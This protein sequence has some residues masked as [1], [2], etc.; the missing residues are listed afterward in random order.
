MADLE[1]DFETRSLVDLPS[2][3]PHVYFEHPSARVLLGSFKLGELRFRWRYG[4]PCPAPLA[5]H[6]AAGGT[7][8]AHNAG[9]EALCFKWLHAHLGWPLPDLSQ[10]R[11]TAA[12]ARAMQ[13]PAS[14]GKLGDAL[15]L[16]VQKDKEGAR[17]MR[18][19]SIPKNG[20]FVAEPEDRPDEFEAYHRYCDIDVETEAEADSRMVPLSETEQAVW[21]LTERINH[22]GVRIDVESARAGLRLAEK[23]KRTL[24][25]E[26]AALTGGVVRK[27][28]E[29][30]KL[31]AWIEEQG[32]ALDSLGKADLEEVLHHDDLPS[33]VRQAIELRMEA[34][35]TSTAKLA[36]MLKRACRDGRVRGEAVYHAAG[37]GRTQSAGVNLNNLPRPRKLYEDAGIR[38]DVLFDAIR[39]GDPD[40]L[41]FLYGDDLGRPLHLL[42]DAIRGFIW[43]APNH[44]LIQADYSNIEGVIVAW[45]AREEWKL[46]ANRKIFSD[47]TVPDLY[48]QTAAKILGIPL[49]EVTKKHWAR[50]AVGKP[51][52]LGLSYQGSVNAF[53]TFARNGGVKLDTIAAPVLATATEE[54]LEKAAKRYENNFKRNQARARELP[55]DVWMA[56][57]IIKNGWRAQNAAIA[58][59][60]GDLEAAA[61]EAVATP[62][63][64]AT[65]ARVSYKVAWGYLWALLPSGR[66]LCYGAPQL[67]AQVWAKVLLDDGTWSDAEVMERD[68]AEK[69]ELAGKIRIQGDTSAKVTAMSVNSKTKAW[70]RQAL[71]GG[72]LMEN[73]L[74]ADTLV[75]TPYGVKRI[76]D[77]TASDLVWDGDAWVAHEGLVRQGSRMT[78]DVAGVRLTPEHKILTTQGWRRAE[79]TDIYEALAASSEPE[80]VGADFWP[81]DGNRVCR[82]R[83]E[84]NLVAHA[85]RVRGG[86]NPRGRG[87]SQGAHAELRLPAK[88]SAASRENPRDVA[89]PGLSCMA[90]HDR[91]MRKPEAQSVSAL[92]WARD[93]C[94]RGMALLPRLLGRHGADLR[95]WADAG[96]GKQCRGVPPGELCL[97]GPEG[98][99][100]QYSGEPVSGNAARRHVGM[101]SVRGIGYWSDDASVPV[102]GGLA[103]SA[104]VRS[105]GPGSEDHV[106]PVFDLLNAGPRHRFTVLSSAGPIIVSNCT[107]GTARDVLVN[108]MFKAE[109]AGYPIILTVYDEIIAEVPRG[110]GDLAA[111]EKLICELPPWAEG[112]PIAAGGFRAKRYKK[113]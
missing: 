74:G 69:G 25:K 17:L 44:D 79:N 13:L 47:K 7:L 27:C 93:I 61:R 54:Q 112:L 52:E 14:L 100:P 113:D 29:V 85:L 68:V 105:A 31:T 92:R 103:Y 15:G 26:M 63:A 39:E 89:A 86:T 43:A 111:F 30:A 22:R 35:K 83:R 6:I 96:A 65:A 8:K 20:A 77:V 101:R 90:Q 36:T 55:R 5:A 64:T 3:G 104:P 51:A 110:F 76:V 18:I 32:V 84:E 59:S 71:Y 75:F 46:E 34:A 28:S 2:C 9:F 50:Q 24:D 70:T 87:T 11:C 48:R 4:E 106:E 72:L 98:A 33:H 81:L 58:K 37:T 38:Q 19:F 12:Q 95:G 94:L 99:I 78:I 62:G 23:A 102:R 108:G 1:C 73:C 16:N 91:Q 82:G 66:C 67:K 107:Q 41:R 88:G 56:C 42:S 60:W 57:E 109:A 49:E 10:F 21:V 40:Y 80:P 53:Y 45:L 97:A